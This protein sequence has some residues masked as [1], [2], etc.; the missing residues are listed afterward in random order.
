MLLIS[1]ISPAISFAD[2]TQK[3]A[4][5]NAVLGKCGEV[6]K[7]KNKELD[8][9]HVGLKQ[10]LDFSAETNKQLD[11]ANAKLQSPLRNPFVMVALGMIAGMVIGKVVSK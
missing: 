2:D 6:V 8:L 7:A 9:C 4:E 3:L 11:E 5:C 1:T 10:S